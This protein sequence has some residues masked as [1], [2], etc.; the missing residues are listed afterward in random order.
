MKFAL[1]L[2]LLVGWGTMH[3]G[4]HAQDL[5]KQSQQ[6]FIAEVRQ[7]YAN[8]NFVALDLAAY[9]ARLGRE[10]F[11][12][13]EWR[14]SVFYQTLLLPERGTQAGDPEWKLHLDRLQKWVKTAPDSMTARIALGA[15]WAE[16][17]KK[18]YTTVDQWTDFDR[19][20]GGKAYQ[21]RLKQAERAL[22][23]DPG[24][25]MDGFLRRLKTEVTLQGH[26]AL[27]SHCPHWYVVRL[28]IEQRR[29]WDWDRFN[30]IFG[31]GVAVEPAYYPLYLIK[32][33]ELM[34]Q[35]HGGKN[36]WERFADTVSRTVDGN[37]GAI[38]YYLIVAQARSFY[39]NTMIRENFFQEH[40]VSLPRV[41]ES[42]KILEATYGT[43]FGRLNEMALLAS[44]AKEPSLARSFFDRIENNYDSSV[45][46]DHAIYDAYRNLAFAKGKSKD[47]A[48]WLGG[49]YG[50]GYQAPD[51]SGL[52]A[53]VS[54][55]AAAYIK[56]EDVVVDVLVENPTS[57]AKSVDTY[58]LSFPALS[59][60]IINTKGKTSEMTMPPQI[61]DARPILK[62]LKPGESVRFSY[63]LGFTLP[64]GEYMLKMRT[65]P[66]NEAMMRI[67]KGRK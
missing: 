47:A 27:K 21:E 40:R 11:P 3:G 45:W 37:E 10:R 43:T 24:K 23:F 38:L 18:A 30:T 20:V 5:K 50:S 6:D 58:E 16:Y 51:V 54:T 55:S 44:L 13:A 22:T 15:A 25:L 32:A 19:Q 34:P 61:G 29:T 59:L 26:T 33:A 39:N 60:M 17:A 4:G 35:N 66:S 63:R 57:D 28:R 12:G 64:P 67:G 49:P 1:M 14:L 42:Y 2:I 48:G 65:I 8:E 41:L 53:T 46:Q 7:L 36:E 31:E 9:Q 56:S 52:R 62:T